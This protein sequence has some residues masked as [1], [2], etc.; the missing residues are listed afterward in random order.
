VNLAGLGLG[1]DQIHL[2]ISGWKNYSIAELAQ[3]FKGVV[4]KTIRKL[5]KARVNV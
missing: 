1:P 2:F 5:H 4:S 3:Q